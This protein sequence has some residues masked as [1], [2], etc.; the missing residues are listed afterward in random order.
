VA[1]TPKAGNILTR[2]I[3]PLPGWAWAGGAAAG[4]YLWLK[5]RGSTASPAASAD[6]TSGDA[7]DTDPG[8]TT[9]DDT[10]D[11]A[12]DYAQPYTGAGLY[13]TLQSVEATAQSDEAELAAKRKELRQSKQ[14][15]AAGSV[16][17]KTHVYTATAKTT[18]AD[19]ARRFGLTIAQLKKDNPHLKGTTVAKGDRIHLTKPAK[20]K[21]S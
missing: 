10:G 20:K 16:N 4:G 13:T 21:A 7:T 8:M 19:I 12:A 2:K 11:N 15:N 14:S 3:G 1:D 6:D 17:T 9:S 5:H 18:L